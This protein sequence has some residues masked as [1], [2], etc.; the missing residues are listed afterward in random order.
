MASCDYC[1]EHYNFGALKAGSYFFCTGQ[2]Y[3]RGKVLEILDQVQP[4]QI[5]QYID[6]ESR[7]RCGT[8][9]L[10]AVLDV[11]SSHRVYSLLVYTSWRSINKL[12]CRDCS[13]KR[14]IRDLLFSVLFGWWGVPWG[15]F[16]TPLQIIRNLRDMSS[17]EVPSYRFKQII[18]L[19]LARR[20]IAMRDSRAP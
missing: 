3:E 18:K 20:L 8:C 17:T 6:Q 12:E 9:A 19:D 14:Q 1:G 7:G 2:C 10:N 11:R 13:R 4:G 16:I 15:L 5:A